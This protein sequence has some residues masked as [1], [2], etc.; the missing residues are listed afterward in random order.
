MGETPARRERVVA[1]R[2][3]DLDLPAA[4]LFFFFCRLVVSPS[5]PGLEFS[6]VGSRKDGACAGRNTVR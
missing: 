6:V 1:A 5:R 4:A 3:L 2:R